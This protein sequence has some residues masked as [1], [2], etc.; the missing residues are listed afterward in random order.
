VDQVAQGELAP[1]KRYAVVVLTCK[2]PVGSSSAAYLYALGTAAPTLVRRVAASDAGE[3]YLLDW[4][5][6]RFGPQRLWVD[7]CA[8]SGCTE[9]KVTTY[10]LVKD[11]VSVIG[12]QTHPSAPAK[13]IP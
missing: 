6:L 9:R 11:R 3:G 7:T 1:G 12:S 2:F 8:S 13:G 10:A 5:H 4:V